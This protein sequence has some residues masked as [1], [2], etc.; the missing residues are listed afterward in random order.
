MIPSLK[1][2]FST[3][4]GFRQFPKYFLFLGRAP[5]RRPLKQRPYRAGSG[6]SGVRFAPV[7]RTALR[8]PSAS[9]THSSSVWTLY[10]DT[11]YRQILLKQITLATHP[12]KLTI[13]LSTPPIPFTAPYFSIKTYY[14]STSPKPTA[15]IPPHRTTRLAKH[16][17][18]ICLFFQT[19]V[20]VSSR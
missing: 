16:P 5:A 10:I 11:P 15:S 1:N 4:I 20:S 19:F 8:A 14:T 17:V 12:T 6:C 2:Q 3:P 7:L 13:P 18:A 9:L